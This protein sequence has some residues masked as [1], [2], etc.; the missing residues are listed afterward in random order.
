MNPLRS[1]LIE[2]HPR[3]ISER[4]SSVVTTNDQH[5]E[6]KFGAVSTLNDQQAQLRRRAP[7]R[8]SIKSLTGRKSLSKQN[9]TNEV[10]I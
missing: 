6:D 4:Q 2:Q 1:E 10:N 9:S 3:T 7:T 5:D 8:H